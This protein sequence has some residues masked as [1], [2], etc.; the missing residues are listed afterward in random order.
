MPSPLMAA[1][2]PAPVPH[3]VDTPLFKGIIYGDPSSGKTRFA[4]TAATHPKMGKVLFLDVEGGM[5]AVPSNPGMLTVRMRNQP[6]GMSALEQVEAYVYY[7]ANPGLPNAPE[8]VRTALAGV[9]TVVLDS[10]TELQTLDIEATVD[11]KVKENPSRNRNLVYVEDYGTN[12]VAMKRI[13][14]YIKDLPV[15]VIITALATPVYEGKDSAAVYKGIQPAFTN[16]LRSSAMGFV[17][18]VWYMARDTYEA[19]HEHAGEERFNLFTKL[20][21]T[22]GFFTKTRASL[23]KEKVPARIV[24][25][26]MAV[27]YQLLLD[28]ESAEVVLKKPTK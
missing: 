24:N 15:N 13:L 5:M 28:T 27:I 18:H 23:F 12:T 14:R 10:G 11:G 6:D 2:P 8:W 19:G 25:P 9:R 3:I 21:A 16:K 17:D 26:N 7:L 4:S 1:V 20:D 22:S